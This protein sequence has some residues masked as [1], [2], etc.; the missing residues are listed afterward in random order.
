MRT[1]FRS[2]GV[3]ACVAALTLFA[4]APLSA[5]GVTTA[6]VRG[7][8]LD[9]TG[10]PVVGATI[11]LT[12]RSTGQRFQATSRAGGLYNLEN[13]AIGGPYVIEARSIGYQP[14]QRTG[15]VLS[16]GQVLDLDLRLTRAAVQLEAI[17]VTAEEA[18]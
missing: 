13:V 16:L 8:L 10:S 1:L 4:A 5:Q 7:R 2:A 18:D 12:N 3:A 9:D 11:L 6:A 14:A 17:A 15:I